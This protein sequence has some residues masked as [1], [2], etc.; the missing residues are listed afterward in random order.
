MFTPQKMTLLAVVIWC[1]LEIARVRLLAPD[2]DLVRILLVVSANPHLTE[3]I[4]RRLHWEMGFLKALPIE[5]AVALQEPSGDAH[6]IVRLLLRDEL[7]TLPLP[8][9][10]PDLVMRV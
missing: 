10:E 4:V 5:I 1:I 8:N 6:P 3:G 9:F 2:G 7:V